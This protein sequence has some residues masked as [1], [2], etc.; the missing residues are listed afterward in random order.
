MED[1]SAIDREMTIVDHLEEFRRRLIKCLVIL[2]VLFPFGF[3]VS[4]PLIEWMKRALAPT[5][6][7]QLVYLQPMAYFFVQ[8]K[9]AFFLSLF[10]AFP[11]VSYQIWRFVSPALFK[12]ERR[13]VLLFS[14]VSTALF[15][16]GAAAALFLVFPVV[17][18]FSVGMASPEVT[19]MIDVQGFVGLAG[20]LMLGFGVMFQL[21]IVVWLLVRLGIVSVQAMSKA[22]PYVYVGIFV[23]AALLTPGPDVISQLAM[24]LPS[25]VLFE[26]ALAFSR[27]SGRRGGKA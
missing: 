26:G 2:A 8:M 13:N 7:H 5:Q 25:V 10:I 17:M 20:M 27:I 18:R 19:P 4:Q 14:M 3:Y 9:V 1:K 23:L 6:L 22:R 16:S 11:F 12:E 21:P 15:L 24:G